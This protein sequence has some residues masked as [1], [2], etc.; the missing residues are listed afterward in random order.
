[1][2]VLPDGRVLGV[3]A[4]H[5]LDLGGAA[6]LLD[7]LTLRIA[8][9]NEEGAG[10]AGEEIR[11]EGAAGGGAGDI[12]SQAGIQVVGLHGAPGRARR[13]GLDLSS[14][15]ALLALEGEAAGLALEPDPR[16]GAQAGEQILLLSGVDGRRYEGAVFQSGPQGTWCL[17][18]AG[19][20]PARMSGSP[21]VSLHTGKVVGMAVAAGWR[22]GRLV[23]GL[24]PIRALVGKGMSVQ[25]RVGLNAP[26][27]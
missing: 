7:Q 14:D 26:D 8:N 27:G 12:G 18:Q 15:H 4:A 6:Q 10:G 19:F 17:M 25:P 2:L 22:E 16:G 1:M 11:S 23:L 24:V 13:F 21:A 20:D 9:G 3:T 5:N